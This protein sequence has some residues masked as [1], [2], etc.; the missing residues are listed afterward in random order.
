MSDGN[1]ALV[2]FQ[3]ISELRAQSTAQMI[4]IADA[5][6][7]EVFTD[8]IDHVVKLAIIHKIAGMGEE[9]QKGLP[10]AV[11]DWFNFEVDYYEEYSRAGS[12]TEVVEKS[13]VEEPV[14]ESVEEAGETT[15][16]AAP[17]PSSPK[18]KKR[19]TLAKGTLMHDL[20]DFLTNKPPALRK[21]VMVAVT[22]TFKRNNPNDNER[23]IKATVGTYLTAVLNPKYAEDIGILCQYDDE[24]RIVVIEYPF[25]AE[26]TG[27]GV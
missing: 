15:P 16:S 20:V 1:W 4:D 23:R 13:I 24:K 3:Y 12:V 22:E 27:Y 8:S 6:G 18:V 25:P 11:I 14:V 17:P 19:K 21:E 26:E 9:E 7:V 5:V 2:I 10:K